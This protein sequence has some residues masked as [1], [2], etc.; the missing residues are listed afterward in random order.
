MFYP[1]DR[2]EQ[3][4]WAEIVQLPQVDYVACLADKA[5]EYE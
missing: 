2:P 1:L 4:E 3:N 5:Q